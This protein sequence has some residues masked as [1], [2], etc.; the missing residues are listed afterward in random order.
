MNNPQ[1]RKDIFAVLSMAALCLIL[2]FNSLWNVFIFDDLHGIMDNLYIKDAHYIPRFFQ[3]FY[4]SIPEI[5]KGMFRPLLLLTFSFNYFFSGLHPL[6]YH[7]INILIHFLNGALLYLILKSLNRKTDYR[8][9]LSACLLFIAHPINSEAVTYISCR[10]DLLVTFFIL[11]AFYAFIKNRFF[12]S[13][14]LYFFALL[15]KE[16]ALVYSL[17]PAAYLIFRGAAIQERREK[18]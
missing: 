15:T 7:I 5:P 2:Y 1:Q 10:S 11:S 4:T 6:G 17:L 16:T 14:L 8:L 12:L 18:N 9:L 3:G 13:A